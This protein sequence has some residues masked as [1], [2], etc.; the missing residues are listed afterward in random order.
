VYSLRLGARK[1]KEI[2]HFC[3]ALTKVKEFQ[4]TIQA[5]TTYLQGSHHSVARQKLVKQVKLCLMFL[6]NPVF[7]TRDINNTTTPD[8]HQSKC[9]QPA[10]AHSTLQ[11]NPPISDIRIYSECISS[12]PGNAK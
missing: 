5:K 12:V 11:Q 1:K 9:I 3:F 6:Q 8:R 10:A 2:L 7:T 4:D